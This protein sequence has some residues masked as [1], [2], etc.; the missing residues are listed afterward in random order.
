VD[1]IDR[2]TLAPFSDDARLSKMRGEDGRPLR[3]IDPA[4]GSGSFLLGA[5]QVLLDWYLDRYL[6]DQ[7]KW[8][9]GSRAAIREDA[10]EDGD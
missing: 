10:A 1:Y 6:A 8:A 7:S 2:Q 3:V 4:C 5:Y 9:Q